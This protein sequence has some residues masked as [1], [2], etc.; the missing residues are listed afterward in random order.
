MKILITGGFGFVGSSIAKALQDSDHEVYVCD[1]PTADNVLNV[2]GLKYRYLHPD[3]V[4]G[5]ISQFGAVVHMGAI[6]DTTESDGQSIY[7][8]NI[9][10]SVMLATACL[11]SNVKF[12]YASSAS[13]Y[14]DG[15]FG[16]VDSEDL[17]VHARYQPLNL[18]A[19]SKH[20]V[21][22]EFMLRSC[23]SAP[24]TFCGLRFFNVY[25]RNEASKG[26][27]AS[28]LSQNLASI[29]G[30]RPIC[31][32]RNTSR[33][34]LPAEAARDFV[35]VDL[36]ISMCIEAIDNRLTGIYNV[37]TGK[38][39]LFSELITYACQL[40]GH[41][42]DINFVDIPKDLLPQYQFYTEADMSKASYTFSSCR[43]LDPFQQLSAFIRSH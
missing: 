25:G 8:K 21:D 30:G 15:R 37:G 40:L 6:A 35:C 14:G 3:D 39:L 12:V 16:F 10:S 36:A 28:V 29:R 20:Y 7:E 17:A 11:E 18:Y 43:D 22:M 9:R 5:E 1:Y 38:A 31:L 19:W 2:H 26:R 33:S 42:P 34:D 27:M 32:F 24:N 4:L 41:T 13:V 23:F